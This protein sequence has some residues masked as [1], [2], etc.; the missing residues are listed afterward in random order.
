MGICL[1]DLV[2]PEIRGKVLDL[3]H[4]F[5]NPFW[6]EKGEGSGFS[7]LSCRGKKGALQCIHM[8]EYVPYDIEAT[9]LP[10]KRYSHGSALF[11]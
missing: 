7:L 11:Q 10:H 4:C 8:Y 3:I 5:R 6:F 9:T 2:P 1:G